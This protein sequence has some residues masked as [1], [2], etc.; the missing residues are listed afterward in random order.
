MSPSLLWYERGMKISTEKEESLLYTHYTHDW[1]PVIC[2]SVV[3][4][5]SPDGTALQQPK[6][7]PSD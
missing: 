5:Q 2:G 7:H 6:P 1:G 4:Q 3:P